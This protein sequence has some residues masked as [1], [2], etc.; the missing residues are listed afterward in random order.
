M[1]QGIFAAVFVLAGAALGFGLNVLLTPSPAEAQADA[2]PDEAI[3]IDV[4]LTF[5]SAMMTA[6]DPAEQ[7]VYLY[8]LGDDEDPAREQFTLRSV[9]D[10]SDIGDATQPVLPTQMLGPGGLEAAEP[11]GEAV[12]DAQ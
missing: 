10:I 11:A 6:T 4:Q 2:P 8:F 1:K 12:E 3:Q 5:G 9:V 7:K